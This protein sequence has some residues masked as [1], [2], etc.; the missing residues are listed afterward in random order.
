MYVYIHV[1]Q[2]RLLQFGTRLFKKFKNCKNTVILFRQKKKRAKEINSQLIGYPKMQE[3]FFIH[4]VVV[5]ES[6]S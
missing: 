2:I 1:R 4:F 3:H 6:T 5:R